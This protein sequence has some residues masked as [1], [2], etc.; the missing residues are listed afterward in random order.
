MLYD[1]RGMRATL[2]SPSVT[3][4]SFHLGLIT[5]DIAPYKEI[6]GE[7]RLVEWSVDKEEL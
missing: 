4:S 6:D 1:L 2:R 5:M 7:K 3:S